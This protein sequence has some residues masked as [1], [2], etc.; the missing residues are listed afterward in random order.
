MKSEAKKSVF[1]S[2]IQN[3]ATHGINF[4]I[5]I[6]VARILTPE[7]YGVIA[8]L[9]VFYAIAQAFIDSG[10]GSALIQKQNCTE[11]DYN[12]VF[13][14]SVIVSIFLYFVLFVSA[15]LIAR[16]FNNNLLISISRVYLFS[17]VINAVG[18]VPMTIMQKELRFKNFA[19]ISLI[20]SIVGG[21]LAVIMAYCGFAYWA[22]VYQALLS[23]LLTSI[24]CF[25]ITKWKL[26][27]KFDYTSMKSMISYGFPVMLTSLL[28]AVYNNVYS[29]VIGA[30]YTSRDLGLYNRAYSYS[31]TFPINFSNFS[32]RAMF[33]V[34]SKTQ[35]EVK[36]L[37]DSVLNMLHMSLYVIV[38]INLYFVFN[39]VD[40]VRVTLGEKW[41]NL[42][43]FLSI[44]SIGC[45]SYIYTNMHI[46]TFKV[47]GET[48]TLFLSELLRKISGI[49]VLII[50]VPFG[51][52][53]MVY[54]SLVFSVIDVLIS[55]FFI[56]SRM[57][58]GIVDH[59]KASFTPFFFSVI[60]G[61][62]CILISLMITNLFTRFF[63]CI[64]LFFL[65]YLFLSY[66]FKDKGLIFVINYF[67]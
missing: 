26:S 41:I 15:P 17:L 67:K 35:G 57:G 50:T 8:M 10:L 11:K 29:F 51:V 60:S 42:S 3:V 36:E 44:L 18:I 40:I 34:L 9:A 6:I 47:I 46:C 22:L 30:R 45:I 37:K 43:P 32:M 38:P 23:T 1:W 54:G 31:S 33:P 2:G 14:F 20:T 25:V 21:V 13:L 12:S 56:N 59:V 24:A 28:Q 55:I 66:I 53:V 62:I 58:I 5:T 61:A 63:T 48:K 49:V 4:V 65:S 27:F 16:I 64:A 52:T 39:S 19:V 7:D